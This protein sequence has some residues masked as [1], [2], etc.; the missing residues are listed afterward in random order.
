MISSASRATRMGALLLPVRCMLR[1]PSGVR[2]THPCKER[3]GGELPPPGGSNFH[4]GRVILSCSRRSQRQASPRER[5]RAQE[6]LAAD[7][8]HDLYLLHSRRD[9]SPPLRLYHCPCPD[10]HFSA[11]LAILFRFPGKANDPVDRLLSEMICCL[12]WAG[13]EIREHQGNVRNLEVRAAAEA[14]LER[15]WPGKGR[16]SISR[17]IRHSVHFQNPSVGREGSD[18]DWAIGLRRVPN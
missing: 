15:Y 16:S 3:K 4:H 5:N 13:R 12:G 17:Y 1:F 9:T 8:L 6:R 10:V 14:D 18:A 11:G 7:H 2:E